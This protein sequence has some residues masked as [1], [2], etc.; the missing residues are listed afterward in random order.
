MH[1]CC[2][3]DSEQQVAQMCRGELELRMGGMSVN[4]Q[5]TSSDSKLPRKNSGFTL[6]E[7]AQARKQVHDQI[8][9][10]QCRGYHMST[11]NLLHIRS[12]V[13]EP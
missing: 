5:I 9:P 10:Y 3:C 4:S 11:S 8:K 1:F 2:V 6:Q 12:H 7:R 13:N